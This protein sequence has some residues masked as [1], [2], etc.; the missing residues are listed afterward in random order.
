M[1]EGRSLLTEIEDDL[2]AGKPL[3]DLLRKTIL[4]GGRTASIELRAWATH[5]LKGFI[6]TAQD[7]MPAHRLIQA[8]L[9]MDSVSAR[10]QAKYQPLPLRWLPEFAKEVTQEFPVRQGVG[11]LEAWVSRGKIIR[12]SVP[13]GDVIGADLARRSG[14]PTLQIHSVYWAIDVLTIA[15]LL[16][17]VR[18]S[19]TELIGELAAV[20][21]ASHN[22]SS[23]EVSQ[24]VSLV[25]H[26]NN[27]HVSVTTAQSNAGTSSAT[28]GSSEGQGWWSRGRRIG[29][30]A[31]GMATVVGAVAAVMVLF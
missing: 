7:E 20:S 19:L 9:M 4:F 28:T 1:N 15:G 25:I 24:A 11:E 6:G 29:A 17:Q 10:A 3:A 8:P 22:P 31:V 5:E 18:T 16:D 30:F 14:D 26:G 23:E 12:I 13:G 27:H 2:L 21:S